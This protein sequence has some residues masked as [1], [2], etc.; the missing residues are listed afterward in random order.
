MI[1]GVNEKNLPEEKS[2]GMI[3]QI[4]LAQKSDFFATSSLS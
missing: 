4:S 1:Y 3:E 2:K